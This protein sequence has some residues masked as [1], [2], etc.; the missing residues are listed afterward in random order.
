MIAPYGTSTCVSTS[1]FLKVIYRA[2]IFLIRCDLKY[3]FLI[4]LA[5]CNLEGFNHQVWNLAY[6]YTTLDVYYNRS[7]SL[8]GLPPVPCEC[9][10]PLGVKGNYF[11]ILCYNMFHFLLIQLDQFIRFIYHE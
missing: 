5:A 4:S 10:T 6:D 11:F 8:R 1:N 3:I 9:P 2:N 7:H